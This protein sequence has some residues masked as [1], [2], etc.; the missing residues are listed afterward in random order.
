MCSS[1]TTRDSF[2]TSKISFRIYWNL[3]R[4]TRRRHV[5]RGILLFGRRIPLLK[6]LRYQRII[7]GHFPYWSCSTKTSFIISGTMVLM[8]ASKGV[9][10]CTLRFFQNE[11][12]II[13]EHVA[14]AD[15][16]SFPWVIFLHKPMCFTLREEAVLNF[17]KC[18]ILPCLFIVIY[19]LSYF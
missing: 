13:I 3:L 8:T 19:H 15:W 14:D 11:A 7:W 2:C 16:K 10:F 18:I 9:C 6:E 4:I 17:W 1:H 12:S 5:L